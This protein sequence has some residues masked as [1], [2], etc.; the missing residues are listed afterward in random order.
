M[1]CLACC[2]RNPHA[3]RVYCWE[4]RGRVVRPISRQPGRPGSVPAETGRENASDVGSNGP[5]EWL[6]I[7][8]HDWTRC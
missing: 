1:Q 2:F 8:E 5:D 7:A 3:N 4:H 6:Q